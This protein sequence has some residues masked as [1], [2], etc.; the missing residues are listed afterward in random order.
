MIR[1]SMKRL[2]NNGGFVCA[3]ETPT[4]LDLFGVSAVCAG[5]KELQTEKS[6]HVVENC[7]L[8]RPH[9]WLNRQTESVFC[10]SAAH[11]C[12][13]LCKQK[14]MCVDWDLRF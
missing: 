7:V 9:L 14:Q 8:I 2:F 6:L 11:L 1:H 10:V 5:R 4:G 13:L 3:A 12:V